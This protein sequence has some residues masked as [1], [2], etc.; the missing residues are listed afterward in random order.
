MKKLRFYNHFV[1]SIHLYENLHFRYLT[2]ILKGLEVKILRRL[3]KG[4]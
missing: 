4:M 1:L 2:L 3:D